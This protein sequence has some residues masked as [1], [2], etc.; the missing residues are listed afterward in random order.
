MA[1]PQYIKDAQNSYNAGKDLIQ[2][3][4]PKGTKDRIKNL[5]GKDASMAAYCC[6]SVLV[7]IDSDEDERSGNTTTTHQNAQTATQSPQCYKDT[8]EGDKGLNGAINALQDDERELLEWLRDGGREYCD[9]CAKNHHFSA[10]PKEMINW[11][12]GQDCGDM[13]ARQAGRMIDIELDESEAEQMQGI[14]WAAGY[15]TAGDY[16][17]AMIAKRLGGTAQGDY[18]GDSM[19]WD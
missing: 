5:I 3:K 9:K 10:T 1:L 15:Q 2:L 14:A 7:A 12:I 16:V 4:L 8:R 17:A 6:Q 13:E 19:P 18:D 11:L